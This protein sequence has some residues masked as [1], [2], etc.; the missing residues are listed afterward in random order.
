VDKKCKIEYL[1]IAEQDLN[2][3]IEYIIIDHPDAAIRVANQIDESVSTL[4]AFPY[5]GSVPNDPRLQALQYR[6]I[7]VEPYLIF[8]V[9]NNDTIEIRRILHGKRRYSFLL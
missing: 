3:I 1:P 5:M 6:F 2:D 9:I 4:K 7:V 8:Y